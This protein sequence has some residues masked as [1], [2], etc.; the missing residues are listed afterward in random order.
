MNGIACGFDSVVN[1]NAVGTAVDTER[2]YL[3][4]DWSGE[5][6]FVCVFKHEEER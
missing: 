3:L 1:G 5:P 4:E 2:Q 6:C